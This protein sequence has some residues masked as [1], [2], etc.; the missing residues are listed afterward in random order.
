VVSDPERGWFD[1]VKRLTSDLERGGAIL[2]QQLRIVLLGLGTLPHRIMTVSAF[3]CT[4][5]RF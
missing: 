3:E 4:A 2:L 5:A 1:L